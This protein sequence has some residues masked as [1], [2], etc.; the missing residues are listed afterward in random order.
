M[1]GNNYKIVSTVENKYGTTMIFKVM[2]MDESDLITKENWIPLIPYTSTATVKYGTR[3]FVYDGI[4]K[5]GNVKVF[6]VKSTFKYIVSEKG[7]KSD[8][9]NTK[10]ENV[11][12]SV[13][14]LKVLEKKYTDTSASKVGENI[15]G[16]VKTEKQGQWFGKIYVGRVRQKYNASIKIINWDKKNMKVQYSVKP[17]QDVAL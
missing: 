4:I 8:V 11:F 15:D 3:S 1:S 17:Y 2:D 7:L 5:I 6:G 12:P 9:I 13:I 16:Y 10:V 14:D